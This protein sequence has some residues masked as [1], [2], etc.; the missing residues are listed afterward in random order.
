MVASSQ[1]YFRWK[2]GLRQKPDRDIAHPSRLPCDHY[3]LGVIVMA[4][5]SGFVQLRWVLFTI[6]VMLGLGAAVS[7]S[8]A[9]SRSESVPLTQQDVIRLE[10]RLNQMEQRFYTLESSVRTLEQQS[11]V[12]GA[13]LRNGSYDEVRMLRSEIDLLQRRLAD[14]ECGLAKVDERTL[15]PATRATR[16]RTGVDDPCRLN[17]DA[18]LRTPTH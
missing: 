13:G 4:D 12:S 3:I 6:V 15:T 5:K 14:V 8:F 7:A 11:R 16:R 9:G 18:P 2:E 1:W 17:F 10:T